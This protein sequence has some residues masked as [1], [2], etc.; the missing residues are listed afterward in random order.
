V[1]AGS[2]FCPLGPS[3]LSKWERKYAHTMSNNETDQQDMIS[4]HKAVL[5]HGSSG[6]PKGVQRREDYFPL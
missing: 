2:D 4:C 1:G 6:N 3:R 5:P